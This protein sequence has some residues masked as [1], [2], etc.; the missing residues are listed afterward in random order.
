[1]FRNNFG[2]DRPGVDV[3][4]SHRQ[5]EHGSSGGIEQYSNLKLKTT[6]NAPKANNA[7]IE[8]EN[9]ITN[10]DKNLKLL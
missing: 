9:R 5:S 6:I 2:V 1:M 3:F 4:I 8:L 10:L 7:T